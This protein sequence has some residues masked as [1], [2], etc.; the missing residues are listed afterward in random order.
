MLLTIIVVIVLD[1]AVSDHELEYV[2]Q[3]WNEQ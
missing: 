1:T 2:G 3:N